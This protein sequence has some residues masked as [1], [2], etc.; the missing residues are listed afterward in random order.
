MGIGITKTT[1]DF[2][3]RSELLPTWTPEIA[4][5]IFVELFLIIGI[6]KNYQTQNII[7]IYQSGMRFH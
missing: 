1:S 5:L 6:I 7:D 4:N 2:W 3:L